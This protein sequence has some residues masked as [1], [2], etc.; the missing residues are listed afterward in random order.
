MKRKKQSK[1]KQNSGLTSQ[2]LNEPVVCYVN[3]STLHFKTRLKAID[4]MLK[5][6]LECEGEYEC[7]Y[8]NLLFQLLMGKSLC[9]DEKHPFNI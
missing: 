3:N 1:K 7:M 5:G 4:E 2:Q 9:S 6:A 8:A